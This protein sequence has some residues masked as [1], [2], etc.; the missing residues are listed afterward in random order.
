MGHSR[1][2]DSAWTTYASLNSTRSRDDIFA[3]RSINNYLD[4][5]NITT[6]ES[7]DSD[8]NPQSNAIILALDETGSMGVLAE[9]IAKKGLGIVM[10]ELIKRVPVTDPHVMVVGFG[11]LSNDNSPLQMTQFESDVTPMTEQIEKIYLEGR[12]GGNYSE[13]QDLVWYAA[14]TMTSIDCLEKRGKKGYLFTIG[15][16]EAPRG[17]TV[18][19]LKNKCGIDVQTDVSAEEALEMAQ[20]KYEV[21]H[22]VVEEGSHCR[23]HGSEKVRMSWVPLLGEN[24]L[25]L[26]KVDNLAEV[27]V[28]A[29]EVFEGKDKDSVVKSWSGSTA[30]TVANAIKGMTKRDGGTGSDVVRF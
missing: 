2:S 3:S 14:A 26:D 9:Q 8:A 18:A 1:Y 22:I 5:K 4:P 20:R 25:M 21:F 11:D 19:H 23:R 30:V 16:E 10:G 12:G 29:I 7:R 28:S 27:I 6:R 17:L 15:D 24:V 13:S